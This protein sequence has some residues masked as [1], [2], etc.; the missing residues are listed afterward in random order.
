MLTSPEEWLTNVRAR[1][2]A[3][4][5]LLN[6]FW[7]LASGDTPPEAWTFDWELM[8]RDAGESPLWSVTGS[9]VA[10]PDVEAPRTTLAEARDRLRVALSGIRTFSEEHDELR[11]WASVFAEAEALLDDAAPD[12]RYHHDLLP[13]DASLDRRR[14]LAAAERSFVF[15]GMGSWNDT[16]LPGSEDQE[17]HERMGALLFKA[18]RAALPAAANGA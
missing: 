16:W 12:L 10:A 14:L 6:D 13:P 11:H 8:N 3:D 1:G 4:L 2:L 5:L 18:L 7:L 9:S 17:E 15:G